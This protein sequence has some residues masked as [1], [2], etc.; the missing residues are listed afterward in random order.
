MEHSETDGAALPD[1]DRLELPRGWAEHLLP[2]RGTRPGGAVHIDSGAPQAVRDLIRRHRDGLLGALAM[3]E[4]REY[5]AAAESYLEGE[6]D[7]L[8]A[9]AV[10]VLLS[11][12]GDYRTWSSLRPGVDA[13]V[14][15]HGL[16]F[17][18]C[19]AIE[20]I[21]LGAR[22]IGS[23]TRRQ[24]IEGY[25]L[26][27]AGPYA[28][29]TI[30]Q[31]LETGIAL[32][33]SLLADASD[34]EYAAVVDAVAARRD[35]TERLL[36]AM[37]LLPGERD[38]SDEAC[39]EYAAMPAQWYGDWM[40]FHAVRSA[41]QLAAAGITKVTAYTVTADALAP[42]LDGL[43][44]ES[45]PVLTESLRRPVNNA[46][47]RLL[48]NAVAVLP[49]DRAVEY[50]LARLAEPYVFEAAAQAAARFPVRTLRAA[51]KAAAGADLGGR[52]RLAGVV[53]AHPAA[54]S[55]A[56][57]MLDATEL[58]V[59]DDLLDGLETVPAA[60]P[61]DLPPLLT[62]PPWKRKR[63]KRKAVV[64]DG[65]E[66][67]SQTRLA[68]EPGEREQWAA[69][70]HEYYSG[71]EGRWAEYVQTRPKERWDG[72]A[73]AYAPLE[74]VAPHFPDW[75][76]P[77][78]HPD[79]SVQRR[80]LA[81]YGETA[82]PVVAAAVRAHHGLHEALMPVLN[83]E[84]A[85]L[86]A[87]RLVRLKSLR[88]VAV[89]WL[90]RHGTDAAALLVPDALGPDRQRRRA[91]E[92]ALSLLASR[93]GT[94]TVLAAAEP[95]GEAARDAVEAMLAT[96]PLEPPPGVKIPKP[97]VWASAAMLPQVLLEGREAAVPSESVEHLITV[98]AIAAPDFP[99]AGLDVLA[100]TCD[101]DSL[102]AFS[103]ALFEQWTSV[104][105]PSK[106]GWALTQL[107]HFAD[108]ETVRRLTALI[109]EWPGQNQHKR[110]ATGLEVLGAIG[111]E[112]ALRA[113]HG[114]AQ[115]VKF[116][117]LK[118]KAAEQ[119][120]A[121]ARGLDL[122]TEQLAD[123]L[124]PDFGLDEAGSLVLDYGP[125]RFKVGFDE[126]LKPFVADEDGKPRKSLPKPGAK[127]DAEIAP[128]AYK[129]FSQLKK[130][131]RTVAA[132]QVRRLERA[133]VE[134]RTWTKAAF[135]E[136]FVDHALVWHLA[137]RLVW[138][139]E[140][141]GERTAFRLA[142]DKSFT[143]V[144]EDELDLPE[145][146]AIRLAHPVRLDRDALDAWAEIFADYEILQ[147]FKQLA[148]PVAAFTA[149]ELKTGR[150]ERFEGV[151]VPV[152]KVLG[153]VKRGW[154]RA[155]PE[156]GGVEPGITYELP[157]G[158]FVVIGLDPGIIVGAIEET[159]TQRL[160]TVKL[161]ANGYE[162]YERNR[163]S[164]H[165]TDVDPV[166]ASEVITALTGV[167]ETG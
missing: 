19:A 144:A 147:P 119:I 102:S 148:R 115:K 163:P 73:F 2:L 105:A 58:A 103:L 17:A 71:G 68:W 140:S 167:T 86:T 150:L 112:E 38:W 36:A 41:A 89:A 84:A 75:E 69:V 124:V 162:W 108:D 61:A 114:I 166:T 127:D 104:G 49:G 165:P 155:R 133:M 20:R 138:T 154:Q 53:N 3:P 88:A 24:G 43:G 145:D 54:A 64:I 70:E 90:D 8:G 157:G 121:I 31:E 28:L 137:R 146:A 152:G 26:E 131:L 62:A 32:L 33:R 46:E 136:F 22:W 48:L 132:D 129:R 40:M 87:D 21:A 95:Y 37:I 51:A 65:L 5:A 57:A 45:L 125:R 16:P 122:T 123:R 85:R 143:D 14:T 111:S 47:R 13:W 78:R 27:P 23:G 159:P 100:R 52:R 59:L 106:D 128:A 79:L 93:H 92:A 67:P 74:A 117:A 50:L 91:A 76:G 42:L 107:A 11:R 29:N 156:D 83:L 101:R 109:R 12:T 56:R 6:A 139:A 134:E 34:E 60:D 80:L 81:R 118:E 130:D 158:G 164:E 10:G 44:A 141:G 39:R 113:I 66:A 151:E 18:V 4:N 7:A 98:L 77:D 110:A 126:H 99:Y 135:T 9:G 30:G 116:R 149:E 1:E 63:A 25:V 15:E 160:D 161:S 120:E 142:E 153:L 55:A 97:P 94:P 96:D 72:V 82:V 35:G